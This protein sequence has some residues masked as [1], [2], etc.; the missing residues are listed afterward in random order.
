MNLENVKFFSNF[1]REK[2]EING[3]FNFFSQ[4]C[5]F[6]G[7]TRCYP[8]RGEAIKNAP[9]FETMEMRYTNT[10]SKI[11]H[12][13]SL[14]YEI[15]E[16][17]GCEFQELRLLNAT[18]RDMV[19][20]IQIEFPLDIRDT[21][22]GGR[23]ELFY[24][25]AKGS[26]LRKILYLDV[27]SLYPYICKYGVFPLRHP[28]IIT[29]PR[30]MPKPEEFE[31]IVGFALVTILPPKKLRLPLLGAKIDGKLI[32]GLCYECMC[33]NNPNSCNHSD[34][35]RMFKGSYTAC[36][37]A[38]AVQLGY[39]LIHIHEVWKYC[40]T[41]FNKKTKKG[42]IF[43]GYIDKFLKLK[44]EASGF[45]SRIVTDADKD[46]FIK[47]LE[48]RENITLDKEKIESNPGLRSLAKM[49]LNSLW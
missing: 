19:K 17:W 47:D 33:S 43:A 4:G 32:F 21:F 16:M 45:P 26:E 14:G 5:Y 46:K 9:T 40:G 41:Q 27:C 38:K 39:K 7:C 24:K 49:C 23:T 35:K 18:V 11:A 48:E 6:H 1:R 42:G 10:Q 44:Q 31:K 12:I 29:D 22:F 36:E 28:I 2:F 25:Y 13:R 34:E 37:I 8:Y 30:H 20:K 3:F 15:V